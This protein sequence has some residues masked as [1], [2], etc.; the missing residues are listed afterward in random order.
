MLL[1]VNAEPFELVSAVTANEA[2]VVGVLVDAVL[3]VPHLAEG[4]DYQTRDDGSGDEVDDQHV[5]EVEGDQV[6]RHQ[7]SKPWRVHSS[8]VKVRLNT[9]Q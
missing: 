2:V 4:V 8:N 7:L 5:H 1:E 3:L 6:C 9:I